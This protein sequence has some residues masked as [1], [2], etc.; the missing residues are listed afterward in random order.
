MDEVNGEGCFVNE[1]GTA[2][3]DLMWIQWAWQ[4]LKWYTNRESVVVARSE[5]FKSLL[6]L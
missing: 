4:G 1:I 3:G 2:A 5:K 6:Y